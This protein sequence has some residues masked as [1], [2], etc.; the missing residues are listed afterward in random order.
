MKRI[1]N[2]LFA[3]QSREYANEFIS[4]NV[5]VMPSDTFKHC[6][7]LA[8]LAKYMNGQIKYFHDENTYQQ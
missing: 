7:Y 3:Q 6:L 8:E 2:F 4:M 1:H 5:M